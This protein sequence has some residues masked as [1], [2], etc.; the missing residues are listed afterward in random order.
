MTTKKATQGSGVHTGP[1]WPQARAAA[2]GVPQH[3]GRKLPARCRLLSLLSSSLSEVEGRGTEESRTAKRLLT[4]QVYGWPLKY[5]SFRPGGHTT[6]ERLPAV[7]PSSAAWHRKDP[8]TS[9]GHQ[10]LPRLTA[11]PPPRPPGQLKVRHCDR[12][13][14]GWA[15]ADPWSLWS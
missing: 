7:L 14:M 15:L 12:A 3:A 4:S 6:I 11:V 2:Q 5:I 1:C 13:E 8:L 10:I 9:N